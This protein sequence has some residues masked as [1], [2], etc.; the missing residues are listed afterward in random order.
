QLKII[1]FFIEVTAINTTV[2]VESL[3]P[4]GVSD[5]GVPDAFT[6]LG[7]AAGGVVVL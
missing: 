6:V 5:D 7:A 3:P 4:A 1:H 2:S